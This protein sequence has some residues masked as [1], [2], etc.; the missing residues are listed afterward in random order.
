MAAT[1]RTASFE[2]AALAERV[3]DAAFVYAVA[4]ADGDSLAAAGQLAR[5]CDA[6]E[7]PYQVSL[8]RSRSSARSRVASVAASDTALAV[9]VDAG[10]GA[11][12]LDADGPSALAAYAVADR[13]ATDATDPALAIA[14][15][16]SAGWTPQG[17]LL[18]AV[19]V[20][21]RPGV[22]IPVADLADGLAHSTRLSGSFSGD[23][24]MAGALL[25]ELGL[26]AELDADAHRR[27]ASR[28]ALDVT[29]GAPASAVD[30]LSGVLRPHVVDDASFE[31]VEGCA[32]VLDA[33]ARTA[34]GVGAAFALGRGDRADVLDAWR[35]A[36]NTVH[37]ALA[38]AEPERYSGLVTVD[39]GDADP[40]LVARLARDFHSV[41]PAALALGDES[42][43][44][45]TTDADAR[46]VLAAVVGADHV[47]GRG[48]LAAS[49][50]LTDDLA[51]TVRGEL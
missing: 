42:A 2:S 28:V 44:L 20:T 15:A 50:H 46:R 45:A 18:D 47:G 39:A 51:E 24:G 37:A 23:E 36:A 38:A 49:T 32:D 17:D 34:P 26:P 21:R 41:E 43:S 9:G 14:G 33:V 29:D 4:H 16:V 22:G 10:E 35:D 19:S 48:D 12:P 1:G 3:R 31:T 40:W 25:A 5:A 6:L 7:T 27:L 13:L 30:A 8:V 11:H